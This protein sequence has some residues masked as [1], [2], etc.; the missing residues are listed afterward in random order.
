NLVRP[1]TVVACP[2]HVIDIDNVGEVSEITVPEA[3]E[4]RDAASFE[5]AAPRR[6]EPRCRVEYVQPERLDFDRL[7]DPWRDHAIA[8]ARIHPRELHARNTSGQQTIRVHPDPESR[9]IRIS[10]DNVQDRRLE[11]LALVRR[12]EL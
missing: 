2:W 9:A 5:R 12:Q 6:L 10:V 3:L 4:K 1:K 8:D 7:S 11:S